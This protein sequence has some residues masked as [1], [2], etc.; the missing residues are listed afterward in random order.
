[1]IG[2]VV[3][4]AVSAW[5]GTWAASRLQKRSERP[6]NAIHLPWEQ[7]T[8]VSSALA[9]T[10]IAVKTPG[11]HPIGFTQT[12]QRGPVATTFWQQGPAIITDPG[13]NIN[14]ILPWTLASALDIRAQY[15]VMLT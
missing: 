14:V 2:D 8:Q 3:I 5:V 10:T 15:S 13:G 9:E 1:M 6:L 12:V 7:I 11:G 4:L